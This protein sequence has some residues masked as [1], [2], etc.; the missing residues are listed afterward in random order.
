MFL[1]TI[2]FWYHKSSII[3]Y[4]MQLYQ[5][6]YIQHQQV[7]CYH[8]LMNLTIFHYIQYKKL[9]FDMKWAI[10]FLPFWCSSSGSNALAPELIKFSF[11]PSLVDPYCQWFQTLFYQCFKAYYVLVAPFW[12]NNNK[13][14]FIGCNWT[15]VLTFYDGLL[16]LTLTYDTL[17]YC[18]NALWPIKKVSN[19][20]TWRDGSSF[21]SI[22]VARSSWPRKVVILKCMHKIEQHC[23]FKKVKLGLLVLILR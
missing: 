1:G 9:C 13:V 21:L 17:A 6:K 7:H 12:R 23:G 18:A 16:A 14:S 10:K 20:D 3:L 11:C 15:L 8:Q 2:E 4:H 5:W 22:V 19:I